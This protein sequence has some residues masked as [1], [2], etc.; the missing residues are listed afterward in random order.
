MLDAIDDYHRRFVPTIPNNIKI[1]DL[2]WAQT[3]EEV[4]AFSLPSEN[5][6]VT[7]QEQQQ[8]ERWRSG[9]TSNVSPVRVNAR[10]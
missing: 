8:Y 9:T 10:P 7:R 6:V 5:I 3:P 1:R 2:I 4:E